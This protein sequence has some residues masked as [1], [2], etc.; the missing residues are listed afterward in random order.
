MPEADSRLKTL[1]L[2]VVCGGPGAEREVS[3]AS[4]GCACDALLEGGFRVEKA[5]VP[6]EAPEQFIE[7]LNCDVAVMMLHGE[8]G[9]DGHAQRILE[10]RSLPFTGSSSEVCALSMDKDA[11]KRLFARSDIPTPRWVLLDKAAG[12]EKA[13][14][15]AGLDIPLVVKPNGRGSSVGVSIVRKRRDLPAALELAFGLDGR[16]LAEEFVEGRELTVGWL[17]GRILPV[18]EL[19]PDDGFYDYQAKYIS[20]KTIYLCPA[21]LPDDVEADISLIVRKTAEIIPVRDL[22]RVDIILGRDGPRVLEINVLPGFTTHSLV[23]LAARRVGLE[24]PALCE[25]LVE[26]AARRGGLP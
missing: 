1:G 10:R 15:E 5:I 8:F 25:K 16:I 20:D 18:I 14:A 13:I 26:M 6:P 12:A 3:L 2:A 19:V 22:A 4:G 7:A 23:P 24:M 17:D 11:C 21:E 9:E